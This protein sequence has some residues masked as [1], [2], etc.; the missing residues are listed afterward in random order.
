LGLATANQTG[1]LPFDEDFG[2]TAAPVVVR[3]LDHAVGAGPPDRDHIPGLNSSQRPVKKKCVATFADGAYDVITFGRIVLR[4]GGLAHDGDGMRRVVKDWTGKIVH[5]RVENGEGF[6]GI[7]FGEDDAGEKDGGRS[8]DGT[9]RLEEE[10]DAQRLDGSGDHPS[11]IDATDWR[12]GGVTNAEAAAEI[13]IWKSDTLRAEVADVGGE[14]R[15]RF[16]E[17]S[18]VDDL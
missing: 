18:Q 5:G 16:A 15:E 13:E 11:V 8:N 7:V 17:G 9:A 12:F 14:A 2:G 3:G 1:A 4:L 10:A 6:G